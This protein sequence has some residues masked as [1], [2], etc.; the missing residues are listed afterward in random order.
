MGVGRDQVLRAMIAGDQSGMVRTEA[1]SPGASCFVGQVD[2]P[3]PTLPSAFARYD[4]RNNR[5]LL[6]ALNQ[7]DAT[8]RDAIGTFD[9]A[10]IGVVIG[11]STSG[12][13]EGEETVSHAIHKADRSPRT[14]TNSSGSVPAATSY[15]T[16]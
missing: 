3:L 9:S 14:T 5:L 4:C 8:V 11:T 7:I 16:I 12:I 1:F 13:L 15:P 10:R 6:A 2:A